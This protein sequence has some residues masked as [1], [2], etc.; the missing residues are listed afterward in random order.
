MSI[1]DP[2]SQ[3][4]YA[5]LLHYHNHDKIRICRVK[6]K[7]LYR[8]F[9]ARRLFLPILWFR[10]YT[11]YSKQYYAEYSTLILNIVNKYTVCSFNLWGKVYFRFIV[12]HSMSKHLTNFAL[13]AFARTHAQSINIYIFTNN[14]NIIFRRTFIQLYSC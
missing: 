8:C 10:S 9:F 5:T 3:N 11:L 1:P 14:N 12:Y 2:C 13:A 7:K 4:R 6:N